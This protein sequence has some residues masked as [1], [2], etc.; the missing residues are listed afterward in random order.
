MPPDS[1]SLRI[2]SYLTL[3]RDCG[4]ALVFAGGGAALALLVGGT[5]VTFSI[6]CA[7]LGFMV[8]V[9]LA[10]L[11]LEWKL[12]GNP[13]LTRSY[14]IQTGTMYVI[15]IGVAIYAVARNHKTAY[16]A[17]TSTW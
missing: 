2:R 3:Q 12:G 15:S 10:H 8:A 9:L 5:P 17:Y 16:T 13:K 1:E 14:M 7:F 4:A 6:E 11:L